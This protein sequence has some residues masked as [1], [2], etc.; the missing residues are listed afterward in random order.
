MKARP[1]SRW[2]PSVNLDR[3][4]IHAQTSDRKVFLALP[5]YIVT[6]SHFLRSRSSAYR[7]LLELKSIRTG[8]TVT[9][10]DSPRAPWIPNVKVLL[11]ASEREGLAAADVLAVLELLDHRRFSLFEIAVDFPKQ[12]G[13][14]LKFVQE[15][16]LFGKSRWKSRRIGISWWGTRRSAKFVRVYRRPSGTFRVELEFHSPWLRQHHIRDCFDFRR[17]PNLVIPRH[18]CFYRL[19][20]PAVTRKIR[21]SLPNPPLAL[22]NLGWG[23]DDLDG[24]LRF[25]RNELS[26][27]NT[28]RFLVPLALNGRVARALQ[29]WAAQWPRRPFRLT[30]FR[31]IDE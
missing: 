13:I 19:D 1:A 3:V 25:L 24:T 23:R 10:Y 22:R 5:N 9:F 7:R 6:R 21:Q 26:F 31:R 30:D 12:A 18:L 29:L 16:A 2:L 8:S 4:C 11:R 28:H 14:G 27:T 15:H 20:W 17:I